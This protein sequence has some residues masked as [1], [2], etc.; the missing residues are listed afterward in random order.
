MLW[1]LIIIGV[2]LGIVLLQF[3]LIKASNK[4]KMPPP[5]ESTYDDKWDEDEEKW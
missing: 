4:I 3:S 1:I 2:V 5:K